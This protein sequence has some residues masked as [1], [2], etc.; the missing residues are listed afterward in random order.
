MNMSIVTG[1]LSLSFL[2]ALAG[3]VFSTNPIIL[4]HPETGQTVKCGPYRYS[5]LIFEQSPRTALERE[6]ACITDY[7]RQGY[8]RMPE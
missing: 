1:V 4:R 5:H 7:Q 8:E 2:T 6:R 3:C